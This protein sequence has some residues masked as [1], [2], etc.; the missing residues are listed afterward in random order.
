MLKINIERLDYVII[1]T[2]WDYKQIKALKKNSYG[3]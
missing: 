2:S 1:I 3:Y